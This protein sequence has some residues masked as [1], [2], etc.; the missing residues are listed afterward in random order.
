MVGTSLHVFLIITLLGTPY[1]GPQV[2]GGGY[3][4]MKDCRAAEDAL[5]VVPGVHLAD[6]QCIDERELDDG[7]ES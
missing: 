7:K 1:N 5:L 4:T 6:H 2:I 3:L